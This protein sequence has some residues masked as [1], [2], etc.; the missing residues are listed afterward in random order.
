MRRTKYSKDD[1]PCLGLPSVT[2]EREQSLAAPWVSIYMF[3]FTTLFTPA[4][5][6]P[7]FW[8]MWPCGWPGSIC[9]FLGLEPGPLSPLP[10]CFQALPRSQIY[11]V[12]FTFHSQ[13]CSKIFTHNKSCE[14]CV[15]HRGGS[16]EGVL[17]EDM[18]GV[19]PY[20]G[21]ILIQA[22]QTVLMSPC[23][24]LSCLDTQ[25]EPGPDLISR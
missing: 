20:P 22:F 13:S 5:P 2:E 1:S 18:G 16:G 12:I 21:S 24:P 3:K 6:S 11:V 19:S 23:V 4:S 25:P 9:T 17:L 15:C 10:V 8:G 7:S 14:C